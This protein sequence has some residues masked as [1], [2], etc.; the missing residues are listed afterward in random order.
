MKKWECAGERRAAQCPILAFL[1]Y[2]SLCALADCFQ[3]WEAQERLYSLPG[4]WAEKAAEA[5]VPQPCN[6][7]ALHELQKLSAVHALSEPS[8]SSY[9]VIVA[10]KAARRRELQMEQ[11][12]AAEDVFW[13]GVLPCSSHKL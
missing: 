3:R 5:P 7:T 8:H 12:A 4:P 13:Q 2:G 6:S 1:H 11:A 9:F 10:F